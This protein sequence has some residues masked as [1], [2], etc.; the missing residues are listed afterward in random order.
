V[1][2]TPIDRNQAFRH[3]NLLALEDYSFAK[4]GSE[5][6]LV[7]DYFSRGTVLQYAQSNWCELLNSG[8]DLK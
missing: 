8:V 2:E 1:G 5:A 7:F 3:P 4:D 6:V